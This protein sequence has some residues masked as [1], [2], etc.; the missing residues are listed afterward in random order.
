MEKGRSPTHNDFKLLRRGKKVDGKVFGLKN[1]TKANVCYINS[2]LQCLLSLNIFNFERLEK[3]NLNEFPVWQTLF[4]LHKTIQSDGFM[5]GDSVSCGNLLT[6]LLGGDFGEQ[7][8]A[9]EFVMMLFSNLDVEAKKVMKSQSGPKAKKKSGWEEVGGGGQTVKVKTLGV[10]NEVVGPLMT[11]FGVVFQNSKKNTR[12]LE[13]SVGISLPFCEDWYGEVQK[14]KFHQLP[15]VL[16]VHFVRKHRSNDGSII[17]V[18]ADFSKVMLPKIKVVETSS[19][20]VCVYKLEATVF[21]SGKT[22]YSGH[23]KARIKLEDNIFN[24]RNDEEC[25]LKY[26]KI[27]DDIYPFF[28]YLLIYQK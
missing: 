23:Y 12:T 10:E 14:M 15:E 11:H 25:G 28:P 22:M 16:I 1:P 17:F 27:H 8:D 4:D 2:V 6:N 20:K 3:C 26:K 13:P 21:H 9:H 5:M 18:D 19:N 24:E 7:Q